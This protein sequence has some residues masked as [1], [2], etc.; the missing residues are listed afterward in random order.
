MVIHGK[1]Y[2][3][4]THKDKLLVFNQPDYP[5]A[6]IQVPGGSVEDGESIEE[7]VMREAF[8]ETGLIGLVMGTYLG[9]QMLKY[10]H[11]HFFHLIYPNTPPDTW[12][13]VELHSSDGDPTP[14][15][16]SLYWV[17]LESIPTLQGWRGLFLPQLVAH[18]KK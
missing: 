7:A 10:H 8:E 2:A 3:Y 13:H 16:F 15:R 12:E 1:V 11:G 4:I 5:D 17:S 18:L 6:G 9:G 14:V